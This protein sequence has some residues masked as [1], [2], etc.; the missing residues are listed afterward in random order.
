MYFIDSVT[1]KVNIYIN[2]IKGSGLLLDVQTVCCI[3]FCDSLLNMKGGV[4]SLFPY[5]LGAL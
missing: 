4:D 2:S 1:F 3:F 5:P